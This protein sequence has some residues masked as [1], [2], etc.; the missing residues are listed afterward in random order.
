METE[1]IIKLKVASFRE[2]P[3]PFEK[4]NAIDIGP[5]MYFAICDIAN[6][7]ADIPMST[8]PREQKLGTN[9]AT[10][11]RNSLTDDS[12]QNF[13]LLNR[14]LLLSAD[15][16]DF[17]AKNQEIRILFSNFNVHG[18]VDGG[19]TLRII[20]EEKVKIGK[21]RQ[22]VKI[23]ILTGIEDLYQ[24]L[25][26]ARN[27][28]VQVKD[29][30]IAE[31]ESRFELIKE[32]LK[33]EPYFNE[34]F[35]KENDLGRINIIEILSI[36]NLFNVD[37]YKNSETTP[38]ISYSGLKQCVDSYIESNKTYGT[39]NNNPYMKMKN[40]F[41]DIIKLYDKL[42]TNLYRF[43][44]PDDS[45]KRY[46]GIKGVVTK[47]KNRQ[48]FKSKFYGSDMEYYTP[49]AFI[50]PILGAF[51]SLVVEKDCYYVWSTDPFIILD[52]LGS[53]LIDTVIEQSKALGY[54]PNAVG[55][56]NGL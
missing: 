28:S 39:T 24:E 29:Q 38:I 37:K 20:Q 18:N 3:N 40:L 9:V 41:V 21:N 14:G 22:F 43:Y 42:E 25:A 26:A 46:G 51:R 27:T 23:E 49:K 8:N 48:P 44:A 4:I 32:T 47:R 17:D 33:N 2:I 56:N 31:L 50:I 16:V 10:K 34:I 12:N 36:F 45:K 52:K 53:S 11:I 13:Y 55:K 5:K 54:N 15:R 19:H 6:I 35:Y 1:K 30:S 7:P